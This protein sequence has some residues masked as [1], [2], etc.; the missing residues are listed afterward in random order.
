MFF[1]KHQ[2]TCHWQK[3]IVEQFN[4]CFFNFAGKTVM[5]PDFID[6]IRWRGMLHDIT[7]ETDKYLS[8][9]MGVGYLG[10]DPTADSLHVGH[11][12]SILL[13]RRFQKAGHKPLLVIGGATGMIG[14]PSGKSA[15]RNLLSFDTIRHN[16][17]CIK[18][19]LSR[20]LDFETSSP[21]QA[22]M[23]NNYD[24]LSQMS[25]LD[26]IRD[27]GKHITVNYMLA[28]DSVRLRI[29][30]SNEGLSFTE[31]SYQLV[32]AVDFYYLFKTYNCKLQLG[33]SDQ[34]GNI[35]TGIEL[36]RRKLGQQ[37]YG[38][39]CPLLTKSDGT[40][41][42]KTEQ[43][44]IWLDPQKT[45]PYEF[46]QFWINLPDNEAE[47]YVKI[48]TDFTQTEIENLLSEHQAAPH[49]RKLQKTIARELMLLIHSENDYLIASQ[50]SEILFGNQTLHVM[51]NWDNTTIEQVFRHIPQYTIDQ[52]I[53]PAHLVELLAT[54]TTILPSKSEV[55]RLLKNN[56]ILLNK[57]K[58]TDD[59]QIMKEHFLKQ[60]YLLVQTGRKNYHLIILA[61]Y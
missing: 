5:R 41:F 20:L 6:E 21:N 49:L 56:A 12:V 58:I 40:K 11:L 22:L 36:I 23:L 17:E 16:Q 53:L 46:Y 28:K 47:K 7:P 29:D 51:E 26:F 48:F 43:G 19:Q 33:G 15:E 55:R 13:L 54:H 18:K 10:I 14:D 9:C 25:F 1:Y 37:A 35:T 57:Q 30:N 24:W 59:I 38:V 44:N 34:W 50:A 45:T 61:N 42:G 31:F 32:Q 27:Y 60:K 39:T 2:K 52:N 4:C 3:R 8:G